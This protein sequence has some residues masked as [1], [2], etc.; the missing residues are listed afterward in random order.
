MDLQHDYRADI[1]AGIAFLETQQAFYVKHHLHNK[2]TKKT[3]LDSCN[4]ER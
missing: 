3:V 1:V 4:I 2:S